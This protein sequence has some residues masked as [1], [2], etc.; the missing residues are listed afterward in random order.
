M[1]H[2]FNFDPDGL[3]YLVYMNVNFHYMIYA[4]TFFNRS[5]ITPQ[6]EMYVPAL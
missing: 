6:I 3:P 5:I 2:N 4:V 1:S